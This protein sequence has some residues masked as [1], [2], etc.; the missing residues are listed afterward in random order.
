VRIAVAMTGP[1]DSTKAAAVDGRANCRDETV[2]LL[3]PPGGMTWGDQ[4]VG[5]VTAPSLWQSGRVRT[6]GIVPAL[7]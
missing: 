2:R 3:L 7:A 6:L 4:G 5:T 1:Q